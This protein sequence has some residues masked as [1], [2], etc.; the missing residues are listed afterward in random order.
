LTATGPELA[1]EA[2]IPAFVADNIPATTDQSNLESMKHWYLVYCKAR[3][4]DV[5]AAGLEEQGFAVYLPKVRVKR[6]RSIG[7]VELEEPIFPRYL[8]VAQIDDDQSISPVLYTAGVQKLVRFGTDYL[9]VSDSVI[10]ALKNREDPETG[11]HRLQ[12]LAKDPGERIRIG[13]GALAGLEGIF[14]ARSGHD[15]VVVLIELLGQLTRAEIPVEELE[16]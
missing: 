11:C 13:S 16:R 9:P 3:Q 1:N 8:F 7:R 2:G 15:R 12:M 10:A 14:E 6:R 4:E 5:A